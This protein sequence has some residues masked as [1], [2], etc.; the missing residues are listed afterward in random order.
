[1]VIKLGF[2]ILLAL[3]I[4]VRFILVMPPISAQ[5]ATTPQKSSDDKPKAL[6]T[7]EILTPTE[8]VDFTSY[9]RSMYESTKAKW[10]TLMPPSVQLGQRGITIVQFRIMQDGKVPDDTLTVSK[11]SGKKDLDEASLGAIRKAA[12]YDHLPKDFTAPFIE[13]RINFYYNLELRK[14][15]E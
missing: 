13:L 6:G 5:T 3:L 1:M 4:P 14:I 9:M 2:L 11:S 7:I 10:F 12:P 15:H 8:G